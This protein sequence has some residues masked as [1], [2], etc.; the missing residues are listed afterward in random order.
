MLY[1]T[2]PLLARLEIEVAIVN[3]RKIHIMNSFEQE[4]GA[5]TFPVL[6]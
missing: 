1:I 5:L 3:K 2:F 6:Q 4:K